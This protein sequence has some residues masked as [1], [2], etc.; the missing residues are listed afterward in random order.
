MSSE[1]YMDMDTGGTLTGGGHYDNAAKGDQ[2]TPGAVAGSGSSEAK[3]VHAKKHLEQSR[4]IQESAQTTET[5]TKGNVHEIASGFRYATLS[6]HQL[7][8]ADPKHPSSPMLVS[9][10]LQ[11]HQAV[12][13]TGNPFFDP[14]P[15]VTF[16]TVYAMMM[17]L[18]KFMSY[19]AAKL[20]VTEMLG[21]KETGLAQAAA[22]LE[23]GKAQAKADFI[24]AALSGLQAAATG[25]QLIVSVGRDKM[26]GRDAAKQYKADTQKQESL[27][28]QPWSKRE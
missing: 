19:V 1:K 18:M 13:A 25:A 26:I 20:A 4:D 11:R 9:A 10:A 14:N 22:T 12:A 15:M 16:F 8:A 24:Q 21:I 3:H 17:Q 23:A 6:Q 7:D 28:E 2:T 27:I 5:Q